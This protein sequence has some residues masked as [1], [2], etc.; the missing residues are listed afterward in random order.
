LEAARDAEQVTGEFIAECGK[1]FLDEVT[2]EDLKQYYKSLRKR[3]QSDRT[4]ANKHQRLRSFFKFAGLDVNALMP[5]KPKYEKSLPT[6]YTA[7]QVGAVLN[8]ADGYMR[9]VIEFGLKCGLRE[10]EIVFLE[11]T[12]IHWQDHVLRVQ[13]KTEWKFK[14]KDSEQRDIPIPDDLLEHLLEWKKSHGEKTLILGTANDKPNMHMLRQLKRL[15][16]RSGLN[17]KRCEGCTG[18][19]NEC[20][21]WTLHKLRRT[22]A[23][24]LLRSGVDL[25]TVQEYMGHKD[26]ASTMR[27]LRPAGTNE[28][29]QKINAIQFAEEKVA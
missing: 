13:G 2:T 29:R 28:T 21:E 15:V 17:C 11:W 6:T 22:Y 25:R 8:A 12:D 14:V 7:K 10:L 1:T 9:L 24:T 20:E 18:K 5:A 16:N 4:V 19:V 27:Y 23:T 26:I 3:G